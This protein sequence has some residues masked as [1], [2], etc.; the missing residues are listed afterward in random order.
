LRSL[1]AFSISSEIASS[2]SWVTGIAL[3]SERY[4]VNGDHHK[5]KERI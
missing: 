4:I 5:G 1:L 3:S 2:T